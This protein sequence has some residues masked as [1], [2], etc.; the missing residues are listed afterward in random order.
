MHGTVQAPPAAAWLASTPQ[1]ILHWIERAP[2]APAIIEPDATY[3]YGDLGVGIVQWA[4]ALAASA[5]GP[6]LLVGLQHEK[7]YLH[8]LLIQ[9]CQLLGATSVSL[10]RA[11][12]AAGDPILA[13]CDFLCLQHPTRPAEAGV[14]HLTQEIIDRVARL[15]VGPADLRLL[16][17]CPSDSDI[18]RLVR[19]SGSTGQPKVMAMSHA[20]MGRLLAKTLHL[21]NDP[22][23]DWNVLNLYDFT[24]RSALQETEIALRLG[25]TAVS[26]TLETLWADMRRFP[27]CRVTLVAGDAIRLA[28]RLGPDPARAGVPADDNG[29]RAAVLSVKGGALPAAVRASLRQRVATHVYHSYAANETHRVAMIG[30]DGLGIV[31]PGMRVRITG[32][33]GAEQP[34]RVIG[35]IEIAPPLVDAYLWDPAATAAAFRDGWYRSSD[36]GLMPEPGRLLYLGRSDDMVS[37][38]GIKFAP[39]ALEER[40]RA[41]PGLRDAVLLALA[42]RDGIETLA[43]VLETDMTRL[44]PPLREAI[45]TILIGSASRFTPYLMASLPRTGT[46]KPRRAALRSRLAHPGREE[47]DHKKDF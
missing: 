23:Y 41:L 24:L 26:S 30:D 12:I 6:G 2:H 5:V 40:I 15:P 13:R 1:R 38:G 25:L 16:D 3:G 21:P 11:D 47:A 45:A 44:E 39:H 37:I 29:P 7:R 33:D 43:V 32:E 8:L 46:G 27:H 10:S 19:S 20:A 22:G 14:L 34:P 17:R 18:L 9:A 35:R 42:D 31:E 4:R 36:L 28:A